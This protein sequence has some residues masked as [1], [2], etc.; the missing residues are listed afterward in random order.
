[1]TNGT[2]GVGVIGVHPERGWAMTAHI[3]A[4]RLHPDYALV[5]LTSSD[6]QTARQA[7]SKCNVPYGFQSHLD[8]VKIPEIDLVVVTV[9]APQHFELVSAALKGGSIANLPTRA[10]RAS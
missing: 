9:K 7:A 6:V 8:L 1:M 3:P 2:I 4:I 5:A 10:T